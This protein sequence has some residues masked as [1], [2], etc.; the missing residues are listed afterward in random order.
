MKGLAIAGFVVAA[1]V[2]LVAA[3]LDVLRLKAVNAPLVLY[4]ITSLAVA[5]A[6]HAASLRDDAPPVL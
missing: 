5:M 2:F 4:A 3:L 6:V 1:G